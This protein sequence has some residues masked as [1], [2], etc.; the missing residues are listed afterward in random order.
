[1]MV[2][3]LLLPFGPPRTR[4]QMATYQLALQIFGFA[5]K[6]LVPVGFGAELTTGDEPFG[7]FSV[8]EH[9]FRCGPRQHSG[10]HQDKAGKSIHPI[11]DERTARHDDRYAEDK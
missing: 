6:I 11:C 7:D 5:A 3:E 9:H 4:F 1:M 2:L 10:A 8:F